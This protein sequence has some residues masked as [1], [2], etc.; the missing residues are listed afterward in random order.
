LAATLAVWHPSL[1]LAAAGCCIQLLLQASKLHT[2]TD[3]RIKVWEI[4]A[5]LAVATKF[6]GRWSTRIYQQQL[7]ELRKAVEEAGLEIVGEPRFARF[8]P[9]WIPWFLRHNEVVLPVADQ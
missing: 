5:Q 3:P 6:S 2:P 1:Q 9:P 7:A 8:D 4:P